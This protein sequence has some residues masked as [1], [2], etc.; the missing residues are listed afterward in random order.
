[1]N[2]WQPIEIAPKDGTVVLGYWYKPGS[3]G[4]RIVYFVKT[5][6]GG[7]W[8]DY[9][10]QEMLLLTH[11]MPLPEPPAVRTTTEPT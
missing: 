2:E 4:W 9:N 10:S 7:Y 8:N 1:M 6:I 11:W 5:D 3:L